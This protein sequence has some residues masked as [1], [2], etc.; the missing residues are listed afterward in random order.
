MS[1]DFDPAKD[2]VNRAKHGLA[3]D[4]AIVIHAASYVSD[5]MIK[6]HSKIGRSQGCFAVSEDNIRRVLD[7]LGPG[8]L[9]FA[10]KT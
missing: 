9:V 10:D 7:E 3:L 4:R 2:A 6:S 5:D 1:I 8:R